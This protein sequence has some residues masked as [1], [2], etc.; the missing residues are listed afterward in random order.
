MGFLGG[1]KRPAREPNK[2]HE[3]KGKHRAD[4]WKGG[5][6]GNKDDSK[7]GR[8]RAGGKYDRGNE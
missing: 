2:Q 3:K 1:D 8:G 7:R 5:P 4:E 6:V